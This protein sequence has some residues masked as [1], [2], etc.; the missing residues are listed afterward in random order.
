MPRDSVWL[1]PITSIAWLRRR[2]TSWGG[3]GLSLAIRHAILSVPTSTA[4]ISA[5]RLGATGFIFGVRP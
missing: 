3:R 2:S 1:K 5:V 4:A